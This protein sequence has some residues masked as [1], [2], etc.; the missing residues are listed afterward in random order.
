MG[1]RQEEWLKDS[2]LA[3]GR[4]PVPADEAGAAAAVRI[5]PAIRVAPTAAL[6]FAARRALHESS[7]R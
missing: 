3:L 2:I 4:R 1:S 6:R 7:L 5:A